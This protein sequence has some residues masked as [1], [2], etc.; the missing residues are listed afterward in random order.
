M[1]KEEVMKIG[2]KYKTRLSESHR[3]D[4]QPNGKVVRCVGDKG[5]GYLVVTT[6]E[7]IE[8]NTWIVNETLT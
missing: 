1:S 3:P 6:D 7:G 8:P 5:N 4:L 2:K